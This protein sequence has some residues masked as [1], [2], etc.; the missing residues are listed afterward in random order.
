MN[1]KRNHN[2]SKPME[3]VIENKFGLQVNLRTKLFSLRIECYVQVSN[4][5]PAYQK[6]LL[7][8]HWRSSKI[9]DE[10]VFH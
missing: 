4:G 1:P 10:I 8:K 3:V 9:H 6:C 2:Q 5:E 7:S